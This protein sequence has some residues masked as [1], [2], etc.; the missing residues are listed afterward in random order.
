MGRMKELALDLSEMSYGA[1]RAMLDMGGA[2]T[3]YVLEELD[4]RHADEKSDTRL[5]DKCEDHRPG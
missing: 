4:R 5:A 1:L 3:P 2:L